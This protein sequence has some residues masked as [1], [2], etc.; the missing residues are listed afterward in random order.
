MTMAT[1]SSTHS[2]LPRI[3]TEFAE[4]PGLRLTCRQAQRLWNLDERTCGEIFDRLVRERFLCVTDGGR[5]GRPP[6]ALARL[7]RP[8]ML[9]ARLAPPARHASQAS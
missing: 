7:P 9:P 1:H 5:Y 8:R 6:E 3:Y 4:M 2:V